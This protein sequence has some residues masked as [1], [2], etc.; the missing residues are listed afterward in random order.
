MNDQVLLFRERL[1]QKLDPMR[2]EHSIG[3]SYTAMAL[4]MRYG[5]SLEKAEIAGLLHDC[6][7][8]FDDSEIIRK[9]RKHKIELTE[10]ELN[11]PAVLHAKY[12]AWLAEWR[13]GIDDQEIISA[14]RWH[15]T[16]RANMTLLDKIIYIADYIEP[17]R[18][19]A[20]DLPEMRQLAFIDLDETMFRI[21]DGT[22]NYLG[23]KNVSVD[24]MTREAFEYYKK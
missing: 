22:L 8:H 14:I 5:C 2:Y 15:T 21:L 12:G 16:G 24:S 4:A 11:A 7:K 20:A 10:D 17:R 6:A 13:Y 9:C 19:K 3:V 18:Y 23:T 1:Q